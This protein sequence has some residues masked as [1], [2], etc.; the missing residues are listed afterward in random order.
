MTKNNDVEELKRLERLIA[1]GIQAYDQRNALIV[2]LVA[3][4]HK[5]ADVARIIN[6]VREKLGVP[7]ITP[8]AIAATIKRSKG[9]GT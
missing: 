7:L 1:K 8:D 6:R 9:L 2:A 3:R 4:G 5:Q